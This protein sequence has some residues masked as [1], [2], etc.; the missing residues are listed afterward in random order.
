[1]SECIPWRELALVLGKSTAEQ[2]YTV[3]ATYII[4]L[5][6]LPGLWDG[7]CPHV[8]HV[9]TISFPQTFLQY[10]QHIIQ[11]SRTKTEV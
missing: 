2:R 9:N 7:S 3:Q 11:E 1:M 4:V 6:V 5:F 8:W 10:Y